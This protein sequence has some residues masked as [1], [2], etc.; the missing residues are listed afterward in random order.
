MFSIY[1]LPALFIGYVMIQMIVKNEKIVI[2]ITRN[3]MRV[4]LSYIFI[5]MMYLQVSIIVLDKTSFECGSYSIY[6]SS[7]IGSIISFRNIIRDLDK[8]IRR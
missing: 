8:S 2:F 7:F 5:F 1:A 3:N 6:L 4:K